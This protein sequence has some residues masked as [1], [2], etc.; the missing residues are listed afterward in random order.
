MSLLLNR[1][2][3]LE[4]AVSRSEAS[5]SR[6]T[7]F[8]GPRGVR[9]RFCRNSI[10]GWI[11]GTGLAAISTCVLSLVKSGDHI[12]SARSVYSAAFDLFHRKLPGW[13][14][15]ATFVDSTAPEAFARAMKPNTK[16]VYIEPPSNPV[17]NILDI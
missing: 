12:V 13:G 8:G 6:T 4:K 1:V 9:Q 2:C 11:Q 10:A 7:C 3:T 14:V 5:E 17:L 16:L 15:E